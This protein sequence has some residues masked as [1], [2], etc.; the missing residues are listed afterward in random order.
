[1][2]SHEVRFQPEN[3]VPIYGLLAAINYLR[4]ALDGSLNRDEVAKWIA[5]LEAAPER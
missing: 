4:R 2:K 5:A 1:M 3:A